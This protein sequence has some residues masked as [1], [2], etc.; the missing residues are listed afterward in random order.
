MKKFLA[1]WVVFLLAVQIPVVLAAVRTNPAVGKSPVLTLFAFNR[2]LHATGDYSGSAFSQDGWDSGMYFVNGN[3]EIAF[4]HAR[5]WDSKAEL[6][7]VDILPPDAVD[8]KYWSCAFQFGSENKPNDM[9]VVQCQNLSALGEFP[10]LFSAD[11]KPSSHPIAAKD[12]FHV[13]SIKL[14]DFVYK[15]LYSVDTLLAIHD[16]LLGTR[17]TRLAVTLGQMNG[18]LTWQLTFTNNESKAS[19]DVTANANDINSVISVH[20]E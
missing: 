8:Y 5:Q 18:Q 12:L 16:Y 19:V 7:Q 4:A 14:H 11:I 17:D 1:F 20:K 13:P 2:W 6:Y 10:A 9:Y 15:I 3:L